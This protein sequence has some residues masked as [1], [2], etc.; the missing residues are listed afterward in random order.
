M[1]PESTFTNTQIQTRTPQSLRKKNRTTPNFY[2][3]LI[4][5][6]KKKL[7]KAKAGQHG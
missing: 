3:L 1:I 7:G 4:F 2:I 5:F 6:L